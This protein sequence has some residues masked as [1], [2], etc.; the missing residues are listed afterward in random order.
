LPAAAL[1]LVLNGAQRTR[2]A[3]V[4]QPPDPDVSAPRSYARFWNP[5]T[6]EEA[7]SQ[8]YNTT[9]T[10]G[11][12]VAGQG[13]A[14]RL[15]PFLGPEQT[16]LDLGC[17]IGRVALHVAPRCARLWAV[18]VSPRM[19]EL[20]R[21]RM[22][23]H[24]NVS[25]A[26]CRDVEIPDVPTGSVDLAYSFLVLQHLER[27]DA[28]LLLEEL[29]RVVRPGG[30]VVLTYPNLLSDVYL[31]SFLDYAHRRASAERERARIYTPQEVDRLLQAAGFEV[32]DVQPDTEILVI[33]RRP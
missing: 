22:S 23:G 12:Q 4:R 33:A 30:V 2:A 14:A 29:H 27:E 11:F 13:D 20:A 18:D 28:F 5:S 31:Q 16:V 21:E 9:D 17:G 15:E 3:L 10:L 7:M 1:A 32:E 6:V 25:Y 24:A 19:L 26:L 8:I